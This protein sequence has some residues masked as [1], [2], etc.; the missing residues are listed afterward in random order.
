MISIYRKDPKNVGDWWSP[1]HR[2]FKEINPQEEIDLIST[3]KPLQTKDLVI[4]GGGGLGRTAF[5][6]YLDNLSHPN[7]GYSLIAWGVGTDLDCSPE[8]SKSM[9]GNISLLGNFFEGFDL[10]G[11]RVYDSLHPELW[12]PCASCMHPEIENWRDKKA[13]R[14][15]LIY[16]HKRHPITPKGSINFWRRDKHTIKLPKGLSCSYADNSG[17]NITEKLRA[18]ANARIVITNSYHGVYWATLLEKQVI[19]I[20]FKSGLYSFKHTPQYVK[21]EVTL[22]DLHTAPTYANALEEC[23]N[24]NTAFLKQVLDLQS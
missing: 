22:D 3:T 8:E 24:A 9:R 12:T 23:K 17:N 18:M 5:R 11:T 10:V 7:K 21:E 20:P 2:Y 6:P 16:S 14:D 19:C 1:P 4:V 15:I 13:S